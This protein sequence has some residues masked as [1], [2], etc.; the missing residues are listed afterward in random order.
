MDKGNVLEVVRPEGRDL[1][2]L[3]DA[4][5]PKWTAVLVAGINSD[6][7]GVVASSDPGDRTVSWDMGTIE[8]AGAALLG[9][10]WEALDWTIRFCPFCG[11]KKS[12]KVDG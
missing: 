1:A 10:E 4:C 6:K 11:K 8:E 3:K 12:V 9:D 7:R 2:A 5:C